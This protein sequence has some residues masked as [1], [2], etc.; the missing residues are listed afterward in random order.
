MHL[1]GKKMRFSWKTV[2]R[3]FRT[4]INFVTSNLRNQ[5]RSGKNQIILLNPTKMQSPRIKKSVQVL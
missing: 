3:L 4:L 2:P 5:I 1:G